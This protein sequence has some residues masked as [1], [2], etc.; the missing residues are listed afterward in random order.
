MD[1]KTTKKAVSH[2][3]ISREIV[4]CIEKMQSINLFAKEILT[5]D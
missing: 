2:T 4:D 1:Q 3:E 5:E